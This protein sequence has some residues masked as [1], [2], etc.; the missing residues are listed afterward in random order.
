ME[1]GAKGMRK[2]QE[3]R[4]FVEIAAKRGKKSVHMSIVDANLFAILFQFY[5]MSHV[6]SL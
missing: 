4:V 1:V 3:G 2:V 6:K 5:G